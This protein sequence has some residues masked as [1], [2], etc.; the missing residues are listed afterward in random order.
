M[1]R[2]GLFML[3][4]I[5]VLGTG[6]Y[7]Y[8]S[9]DQRIT[10]TLAASTPA[11]GETMTLR[12]GIRDARNINRLPYVIAER[13]GFFARE[14]LEVQA[15]YYTAP[16]FISSF[17]PEGQLSGTLDEAME[18]GSIDMS[19]AQLPL[20]I[21]DAISGTVSRTYVGIAVVAQNPVYFLAVRPEIT[22][23]EDLVGKTIAIT[24]LH[25]GITIWLQELMVQNGIEE[26]EVELNIISGSRNRAACLV[27]GECDGAILAQ[28][29]VFEALDAGFHSLGISNEI[30]PLQ[31]MIDVV[32]PAWA[33]EN[34]EIVLRYIR[35]TTAAMDFIQ[36]PANHEEVMRITMDFMAESEERS[37]TML[38]HIWDPQN[39]VLPEEPEIDMAEISEAIALLGRYGVL[40]ETWPEAAQ[41]VD[42]SYSIAASQ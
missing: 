5:V 2:S 25:D 27:S 16:F 35:A 9:Q 12:Y 21:H 17:R 15:L 1:T 3:V 23:Y 7:F 6:A 29:A 4:A 28:P 39:R 40:G 19:R 38:S 26:G 20:L 42:P 8:F 11:A 41:F 37:R 18:D 32:D 24:S 22:S 14:G 30:E 10:E 33:E 36:D 13:Q 31:F 34:R